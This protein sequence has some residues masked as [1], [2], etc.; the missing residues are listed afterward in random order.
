M[1]ALFAVSVLLPILVGTLPP[2]I[3]QDSRGVIG[4]RILDTQDAV[5]VGARVTAT[6]R[7]SGVA[8]SAGTNNAGAFRLPFLLPGTYRL[9]AEM[10]G[11]RTYSQSDLELRVADSLDLTLRL[12]V[13][14]V[15]ET[16]DVKGGAPLLDTAG[17]SVG[18]VIDVRRLSELPQRG[19][20]PLELERL[21]PGVA[22][23][24]TLR[25]MKLSSPDATSA[26]TVNGS[27]NDQTQYNI[28]G[29]SD[30][31]NDRGKGYA[32]VAFIPP[33]AS[34][35]DFK[36]QANPY[37]ASAG[38]VLGP[39]I[40]VGTKSGGNAVHGEVYYW[41]RNSA[42]D[43]SNFFDNKAG[44]KKSVYPDH[45]Y[46]A[47]LGGPVFI[48]H[49]YEGRNK[50]F[51]FYSWE[52]N[53]FG[54]PSISNQ[55]STVPTA[56]ERAGDFSALLALGSTYQIY[57]PFST[58]AIAGGRYQRTAF[59]GNI[60]PKSLLNPVGL[61]LAA[62]Y[63]L[64]SQTGTSNGQNNYYFPDV[65][66]QRYDSHL[67]RFDHVF[68]ANHRVF[69][70][71]NHFGYTIPKDLLGVPAT[72]E[73][74]HQF[75]QG[76][77]LDYVGVLSPTL[78]LNVRYGV[79]AAIFPEVRVTQGTD[80][81]ALGFS[82]ALTKLVNPAAV[83]VPRVGVAGFATL[84]NWSDGDGFASAITH[85]LIADL[86]KQ[87]G[88][89][90]VHFGAD[91]RLFRTFGNR[92][93]GSASPDLS[94]A[95]TYTK[96]PLD[97]SAAAPLGQELAALLLGI[98][99]GSLTSGSIQNY[100]TQNKYMGA[101]VQ[102]DFKLTRKVTINVGLRYERELPV[103]ERYNRLL[104]TFDTSVNSPV[105]AQAA[106]NYAKSPIPELPVAAFAA[107]GGLT[108]VTPNA[109]SPYGASNNWLPR[110]GLAYQINDKT[111]FR[112]G[113]GIYFGTIGVD[114]FQ[115]VQTGF[116]QSTPIQASLDNGVTYTS[117][118]A[119]PLPNGLI[120]A[121]GSA[122]GLATNLGQAIQFFDPNMK[123]PYS[124]RWS[125]G[126]QRSLPG[127]FVLDVSYVGNRT[128]HLAVTK[129]INFT[130]AKYLS[131]S[132]VRDATTI[133]F[134]TAQFPNPFSGLNSVYTLQISRAGL[135]TP[136]PQFG[137]ISVLE[138]QG[139][140][141]Y[142]SL[143]VRLER[144]FSQGLT[145]QAGYTYSK[146][147]QATEFQ[148]AS[149]PVPYRTVS[150]LD[151]PRILT[152]SGV[153]ELPYGAGKRFGAHAPAPVKIA[154][155][156]WQLNG[157][158]VRQ[159]GAPLGFGNALFTGDIKN[160]PLPPDQQSPDRWFNTDAGF[161]KTTAAQLANNIQTFPIRFSGVRADGQATWS[162]SLFRNYPIHERV[163]A[164][165]R[166]EVYNVMN[167]PSFDV[168]N[169][170]PTSSSFGIPTAVVSEPRNWQ[171][172]LKLKF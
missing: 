92:Y 168:P 155:G 14:S 107:K 130:P 117:T 65:R 54:Q 9:T 144:R 159:A 6:N 60:L 170:T 142:H 153:W 1:R 100:A 17:S 88:P 10:A 8:T 164:Q 35:Q 23:T 129:Q 99:G 22:N 37:D 134:L 73:I 106:I 46:G 165:F 5:V 137:A 156:G 16:V 169:T 116:S 30:T 157:T 11:F 85:N 71:I 151:R 74:F 70:R 3:A 128:T 90:T 104:G 33:S 59:P 86:T 110:V 141:W 69:A 39:V 64:P 140:S 162:F 84:S 172:A 171:L 2:L 44:L 68:N 62:F 147:M 28:D 93:P 149:D 75:N 83:T 89:H 57:N 108:F 113:Y 52:E 97:N 80:L 78:V 126:I 20:N 63:P 166:A 125:G 163:T 81:G 58:Q 4:G 138:P 91:F 61:N 26:N 167:H 13:G 124:Q 98:P 122:G 133:N 47:A 158:V 143:Q 111:V 87:K 48:P 31:T 161:V 127:Q 50:T 79:T 101:Y 72:K 105:A 94:F 120:P 42:F 40:N 109:R 21:S 45:R 95:N 25:I 76:L 114:T 112:S 121:A 150:D 148:N 139:Y 115:P 77:A 145:L 18:D 66:I 41:G 34:I 49:F 152:L 43:S 119:N 135:L 82:S 136:Y 154:L 146:F 24:T 38:H 7:E 36:L 160:I 27:G 56:A 51:W 118:L 102:D 132:P 96:G 29:V 55:T 131:T 32:R 15:S 12:E 19:G 123:A 53:R 67:A 103:T